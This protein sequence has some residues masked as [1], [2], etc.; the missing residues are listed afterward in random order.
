MNA[1]FSIPYGFTSER[2][3]FPS[4]T[5]NRHLVTIGGTRSGKGASVIVQ[6]L[7]QVPHS[8]LVSDPK[9]QLAAVTARQRRAMG[10]EVC[11]L[12]PFACTPGNH[13][14][15]PATATTPS[16]IWTSTARI[17]SPTWPRFR[18]R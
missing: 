1:D 15:C 4:Y 9:G 18:R 7:L 2:G 8:V 16:P 10:Q 12:N 13:G 6:A 11:F 17:S 5:D 3:T 14:T